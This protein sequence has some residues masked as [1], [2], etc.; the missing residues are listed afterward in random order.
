[1]TT[2]IPGL[3]RPPRQPGAAAAGLREGAGGGD[4]GGQQEVGDRQEDVD[5]PGDDRVGPA[6]IEAGEEAGDDAD[7][8]RQEGRDE[9]DDQRDPSPVDGAAED[10]AAEL[11]DA[12]VVLGGGAG[13]GREERIER[14]GVA[15]VEVRRTD[16]GDDLRREDRDQD[17]QED[18]DERDESELVL[19]ELEPEELPRRTDV[20]ADL[21]IDQVR[22]GADGHL[23]LIFELT[24]FQTAPNTCP[25]RRGV[26]SPP[27]DRPQVTPEDRMEPT[28]SPPA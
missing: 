14:A 5:C 13:R 4:A 25:C 8:G 7:D 19:P 17:E 22:S 20:P 21:E 11:V 9:G 23:T 27:L 3:I 24:R 10:V 16:E 15:S 26:T 1:M 6:A 2:P 12:E 28:A 18:E